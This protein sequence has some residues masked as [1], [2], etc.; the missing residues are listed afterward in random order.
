M[1]ILESRT[2]QSVIRRI[3]RAILGAFHR[4]RG[5]PADIPPALEP[6]DNRGD[7][8]SEPARAIATRQ[9]LTEEV[10]C[11]ER[12]EVER[13]SR[14]NVQ[15]GRATENQIVWSELIELELQEIDEQ[16]S[17][18][19]DAAGRNPQAPTKSNLRKGGPHEHG[20]S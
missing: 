5:T 4:R 12:L 13:E 14:R 3:V 19:C 7:A 15:F 1:P 10:A 2:D 17:R 9:R 20:N 18:I 6:T 16:V 8:K 11:L